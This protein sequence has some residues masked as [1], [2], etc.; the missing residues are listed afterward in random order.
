[1]REDGQTTII[2]KAVRSVRVERRMWKIMFRYFMIYFKL[3]S[4]G[5]KINF[6]INTIADLP[7]V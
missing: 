5:Y 7:R 2:G 3:D 4:L 6:T 1:M